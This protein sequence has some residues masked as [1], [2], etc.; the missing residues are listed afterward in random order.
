MK[1]EILAGDCLTQMELMDKHSV[2]DIITD[3]PYEINMMGHL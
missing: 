2:D 1:Y 3:P